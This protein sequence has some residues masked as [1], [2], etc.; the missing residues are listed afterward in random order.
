MD[1][2]F[3]G[4][5]AEPDED[6]EFTT[7]VLARLDLEVDDVEARLAPQPRSASLAD[8]H[9]QLAAD[10][11]LVEALR[12]KGFAGPHYERVADKLRRYGWPVIMSWSISGE[13]F[14]QCRL[15]GRPIN[16][17]LIVP[18]WD[19]QDCIDVANETIAAGLA[20]FR[21]KAL[22]EQRWRPHL[23]ASLTTYF[24]GACLRAFPPAYTA[25][26]R[27]RRDELRSR[28]TADDELA[29]RIDLNTSYS[30]DPCDT[31]VL[32]QEVRRVMSE[33]HDPDLREGIVWLAAGFTQ[34]EAAAMA[35]LTRKS[36][37]RKLSRLRAKL[38]QDVG[39]EGGA[40]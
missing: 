13:I 33:I 31:A 4:D 27:V 10:A 18:S 35:G 1:E 39:N 38:K 16:A 7:P 14:H 24:I 29:R 21:S 22:V 9:E 3:P 8:R 12:E 2:R 30:H 19:R 26:S 11:R 37:E 36:L 40:R 34:S 23:G 32:Q 15:I 6:R 20:L 5:E 17:R 25:W 28:A